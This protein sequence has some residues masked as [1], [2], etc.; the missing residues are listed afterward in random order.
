MSTY[1]VKNLAFSYT[2]TV[3]HKGAERRIDEIYKII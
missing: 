2:Q 1:N 3:T